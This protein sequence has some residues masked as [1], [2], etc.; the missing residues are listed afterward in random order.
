MTPI[1]AIEYGVI[2]KI[3]KSEADAGLT[4]SVMAP[5]DWDRQAGLVA[6]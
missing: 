2:D 3:V 1:D 6:R 4:S 5:A